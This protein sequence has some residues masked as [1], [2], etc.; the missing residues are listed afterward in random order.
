MRKDEHAQENINKRAQTKKKT[1]KSRNW[2]RNV[3]R[4]TRQEFIKSNLT[5]QRDSKPW[6]A[7]RSHWRDHA[8]NSKW[9][10]MLLSRVGE[11]TWGIFQSSSQYSQK[12]LQDLEDIRE[13][14]KDK[15]N[16]N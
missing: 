2:S 14:N 3:G 10:V 8:G 6:E 15:M 4:F 16:C 11:N 13:L 9:H 5:L 1:V 7:S 12:I